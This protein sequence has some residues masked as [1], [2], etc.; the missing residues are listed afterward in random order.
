MKKDLIN[1]AKIVLDGNFQERVIQFRVKACIPFN[2]NGIQ[3][4]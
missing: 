4:L 1:K 3:D 2:G